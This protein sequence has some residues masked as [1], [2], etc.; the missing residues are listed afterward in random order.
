MRREAATGR[1]MK[2]TNDPGKP[3]IDLLIATKAIVERDLQLTEHRLRYTIE[4]RKREAKALAE[5]GLSQREIASLTGVSQAQIN[6][7]INGSRLQS[8]RDY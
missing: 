5:K 7:D 4:A 6:K 1:G 3:T 8:D 2:P